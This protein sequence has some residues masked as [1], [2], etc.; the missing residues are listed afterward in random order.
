MAKAT[1]GTNL[2]PTIVSRIAKKAGSIGTTKVKPTDLP[3]DILIESVHASEIV[4]FITDRSATSVTIRHKRGHGSSA[5]IVSTFGPGQLLTVLGEAGSHGQVRAIVTAPVCELK[6][7][8]VKFDGAIIIA[9]SI[10][11]GEVINVNTNL[12]GYTVRATVNENAAAK[13]YGTAAPVKN[14]KVEKSDKAGK[15]AKA[16]KGGK[17]KK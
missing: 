12:P 13:K 1:K 7:Y 3:H 9:T 8:T 14:K 6:G 2:V 10:E 11:T 5:Q 16:I 17:V 15:S 4:G